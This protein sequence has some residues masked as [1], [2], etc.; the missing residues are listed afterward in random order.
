[1]C[2]EAVASGSSPQQDHSAQGLG[3]QHL[4]TPVALLAA[5]VEVEPLLCSEE[6]KDL[7]RVKLFHWMLVVLLPRLGTGRQ[8]C[9][10]FA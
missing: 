5:S 6:V 4:R 1:M 10:C 7:I 9:I 3:V 2:E 8:N